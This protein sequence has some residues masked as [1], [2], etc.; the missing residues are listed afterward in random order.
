[1]ESLALKYLD[2][3]FLPPTMLQ[4]VCGGTG[5]YIKALCEG[6]DEM[7]G[8]NELVVK[9][10]GKCNTL[11]LACHGCKAAV[12]LEDPEFYSTGEIHESTHASAGAYR[13]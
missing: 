10:Y 7:P 11:R 4:I 1:M 3:T 5:L 8:V 6:L 9:E 13:L 2:E 12:Q